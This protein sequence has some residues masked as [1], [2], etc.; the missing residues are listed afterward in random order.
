MGVLTVPS[1]AA[2]PV[3]DALVRAGVKGLLSFAPVL[4]R[5]PRGVRVVTVDLTIQF[6]QLA[7]LVR[8]GP[9]DETDVAG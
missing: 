7:F 4:L 5:V 3:A 1:E 8:H 6:E 2:Q 9:E